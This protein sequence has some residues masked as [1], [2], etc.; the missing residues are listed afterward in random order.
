MATLLWSHSTAQALYVREIGSV[1]SGPIDGVMSCDALDVDNYD[2]DNYRDDFF[3]PAASGSNVAIDIAG[4]ATASE[5]V[6]VTT[7]GGAETKASIGGG[8]VSVLSATDPVLHVPPRPEVKKRTQI[9]LWSNTNGSAGTGSVLYC[10]WA[11]AIISMGKA[12]HTF[13]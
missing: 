11:D 10:G 1:I 7:E 12:Q 3:D 2:N 13:I 4:S 9:R 8:G 5:Y 6:T